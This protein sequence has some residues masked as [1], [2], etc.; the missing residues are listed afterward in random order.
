MDK[1]REPQPTPLEVIEKIERLRRQ[2]LTGKQIA[3]E[4]GVA[5]A[6]DSSDER[7]AALPRWLHSPCGSG[8]SRRSS[9]AR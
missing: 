9:S 4:A 6:T 1:G 2:R 8:F 5:P 3:A 7:T